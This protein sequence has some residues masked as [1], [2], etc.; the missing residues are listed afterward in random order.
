MI[1]HQNWPW[2]TRLCGHLACEVRY[3]RDGLCNQGAG[4]KPLQGPEFPPVS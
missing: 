3:V 1:L 2:P 4:I